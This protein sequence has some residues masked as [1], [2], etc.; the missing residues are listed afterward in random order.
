[1]EKDSNIHNQYRPTS[2]PDNISDNDL[3][4]F[5]GKPEKC[6]LTVAG[7][8]AV[9]LDKES[10]LRIRDSFIAVAGSYVTQC[11]PLKEIKQ[12]YG[13]D[14]T[15]ISPNDAIETFEL[16]MFSTKYEK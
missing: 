7:K 9:F 13:N 2:I 14:L 5:L 10:T 16:K 1:M 12:I 4:F 8:V 3:M 15:Y 11:I 6:A